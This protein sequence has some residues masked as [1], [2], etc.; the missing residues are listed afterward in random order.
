MWTG[1]RD[2]LWGVRPAGGRGGTCPSRLSTSQDKPGRT[3][4][5]EGRSVTQCFITYDDC[6]PLLVFLAGES[7]GYINGQ[8]I[9]VDGGRRLIV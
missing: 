9:G 7:A 4:G 5:G 1:V 6:T 3:A 8:A 2:A